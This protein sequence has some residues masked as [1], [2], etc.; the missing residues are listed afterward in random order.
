MRRR[1]LKCFSLMMGTWL[2]FQPSCVWSG[3][4]VHPEYEHTVSVAIVPAKRCLFVE[5]KDQW[6][7]AKIFNMDLMVFLYTNDSSATFLPLSTVKRRRLR[8]T[9][10][11]SPR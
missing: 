2:F 3:A 7:N 4:V 6:K 10:V 5:L 8:G 11:R 9:S 1:V